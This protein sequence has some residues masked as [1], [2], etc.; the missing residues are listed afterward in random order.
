MSHIAPISMKASLTIAAYRIVTMLTSTANTCKVPA[1][2]AERP[3]G[4]T[5]DTILD[6]N[7]A[8]PVAIAGIAKLYFN[9]TVTSGNMVASNNAGQ[10][11]PHVDV[12]AGSYTVGILLG[13]TIAAT[14]T[15][16]EVLI[17]PMFK[18]IP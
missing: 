2:A 7:N 3:F 12:T 10:G 15:I 18:S 14:G 4:I 16:A 6:T 9:D 13:P 11:V 8:I 1:S 17:Q 5:T